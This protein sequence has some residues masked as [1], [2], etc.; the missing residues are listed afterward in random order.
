MKRTI[1]ILGLVLAL[2]VSGLQIS[3]AAAN[4]EPKVILMK[5]FWFADG[6]LA[7]DPRYMDWQV[8]PEQSVRLYESASLT[9]SIIA[10]L[11]AGVPVR[12]QN[13]ALE[14]Y[15][16]LQQIRAVVSGSSK[17]G[18]VQ[19]APGDIISLICYMGDAMAAFIGDELVLVDLHELKLH[20][21]V[22]PEWRARLYGAN[23]WLQLWTPEGKVGWARFYADGQDS[24]RG[25]WRI[26]PRAVGGRSNFNTIV[27]SP[28]LPR[29]QR[30]PR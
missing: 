5:G 23:Q 25:R 13:I 27:F 2:L 11:V 7:D 6:Y 22:Q 14:A 18:R 28:E 10:E 21:Q 17:D 4:E 30:L 24:S 12:I 3:A 16:G 9:T 1:C 29:F 8:I 26:Q 15:P 19:I 20:D